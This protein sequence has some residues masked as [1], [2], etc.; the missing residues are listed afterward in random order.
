MCIFCVFRLL[1]T[2]S[3]TFVARKE[4]VSVIF[5]TCRSDFLLHGVLMEQVSVI[6]GL[7]QTH[8]H[9]ARVYTATCKGQI[10]EESRI[11]IYIYMHMHTFSD[12]TTCLD[13]NHMMTCQLLS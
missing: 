4:Q 3:R 7:S 11:Y 8:Q 12:T 10:D 13:A 5:K 1:S 9:S 2:L 6:F